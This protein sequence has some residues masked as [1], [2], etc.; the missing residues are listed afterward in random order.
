MSIETKID[1]ALT[2][3]KD[4]LLELA[5]PGTKSSAKSET[6]EAPSRGRGRP[7]G[8]KGKPKPVEEEL[9]EELEEEE[10]L[11]S[12]DLG[13]ELGEEEEE[14]PAYDFKTVRAA[15]VK[16]RDHGGEKKNAED[17]KRVMTKFA[18]KNF[19][20]L[21]DAE[22]EDLNKVMAYIQ[23]LAAKKKIKL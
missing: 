22:P 14:E 21:Q 6:A 10:G 12:D 3:F 1:Q 15:V 13:D 16:L 18:I 20:D 19:N 5:K 23:Q 2:L 9:E 17:V 4:I 8:A 7:A 11:D